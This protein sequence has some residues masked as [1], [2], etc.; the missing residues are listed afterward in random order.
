M[1]LKIER[2]DDPYILIA[3]LLR[4]YNNVCGFWYS[5]FIV[6][7]GLKDNEDS[8]YNY[9]NYY[10]FIDTDNYVEYQYD[11]WDG[12]KYIDFAGFTPIYEME[13]PMIILKGINE[14]LYS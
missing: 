4:S 8:E 6:R 14:K 11:W 3:N 2:N 13:E 1:E 10:L 5:E 12:Q 9:G 7:I